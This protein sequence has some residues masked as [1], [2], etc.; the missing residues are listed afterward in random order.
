MT[1]VAARFFLPY[2]SAF[3]KKAEPRTLH[4]FLDPEF[5][6]QVGSLGA[7][8]SRHAA[9]SLR[10]SPG[11][12][13]EVG[14]GAGVR[15]M[16]RVA[17][18]EKTGLLLTVEETI[19]IPP[20]DFACS[21]A[22]APTK[23]ASRFE[24][25]AEKAVEMGV[26]E[27]IPLQTARTERPRIN[28]GRLERIIHSAA[29]QS[30]RA[31]LPRL[32]ALTDFAEALKFGNGLNLIAH[33][34]SGRARKLF[35]TAVNQNAADSVLILIGPEGD[36]TPGEIEAAAA[37]GFTE[38]DLGENRLR[39]ETAGVYCAALTAGLKMLKP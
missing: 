19:E 30:R 32:R 21:I 12:P 33:C 14:N 7:D 35:G 10:I 18:V 4:Y 2:L 28:T 38:V 37:A 20:P 31:Y 13:I 3:A 29:K 36:F 27:I 26:S 24:W 15:Y 8:E 23:N 17:K 25:F 9:K 34:E 1:H 11:D 6:P 5:D 16:C 22:L 39:T